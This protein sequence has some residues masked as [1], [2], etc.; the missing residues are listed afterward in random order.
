ML[1][2]IVSLSLLFSLFSTNILIFAILFSI[3]LLTFNLYDNVLEYLIMRNVKSQFM[4]SFIS[5][6]GTLSSIVSTIILWV[7]S[8]LL[9]FQSLERVSFYLIVVFLLL[10]LILCYKYYTVK[11][12]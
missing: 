10:S 6:F 8:I 3:F 5:L 4:S 1:I 2:S 7:M 11:S 12:K 9:S